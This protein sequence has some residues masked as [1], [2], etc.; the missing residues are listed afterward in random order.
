M[1]KKTISKFWNSRG[2]IKDNYEAA[3]NGIDERLKYDME[4]LEKNLK[5]NDNVLDLGC[6]TGIIANVIVDKVQRITAVDFIEEFVSRIKHPKID[7][8]C[9]E[10]MKFETN[11]KFDVIIIFGVFNYLEVHEVKKL[12]K[13]LQN[14]VKQDGIIIIKHQCGLNEDITVDNYSKKLQ[15]KYLA[16]YRKLTKEIMLLKNY[17]NVDVKDI[18]PKGMNIWDNTHHYA[19]ICKK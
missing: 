12:C 5:K 9:K 3:R 18:Y 6:G 8:I 13:K 2:L 1:D 11:E 4:L 15:C 14:W 7:A 10:I 17:F 16:T 19:F